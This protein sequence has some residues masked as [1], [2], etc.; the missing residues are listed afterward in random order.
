MAQIH[1]VSVGKIIEGALSGDVEK[2]KAY[3]NFIADQLEKDGEAR[4]ARIIRSKLDGS[5]KDSPKITLDATEAYE[6]EDIIG[7]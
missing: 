2:V 4:C 7:V 3:A 1:V 5:Y 6:R